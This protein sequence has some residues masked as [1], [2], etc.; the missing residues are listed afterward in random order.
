MYEVRTG[1][2]TA[3]SYEERFYGLCVLYRNTR[4][5]ILSIRELGMATQDSIEDLPEEGSFWDIPDANGTWED[6]E[7]LQEE[8]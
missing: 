1:H 5:V 7:V 2:T 8:E 4:R 3:S 6:W